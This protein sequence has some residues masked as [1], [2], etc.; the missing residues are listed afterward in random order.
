MVA[1]S[2]PPC[3]IL[4]YRSLDLDTITRFKVEIILVGFVVALAVPD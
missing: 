1:G 2:S 4:G 3:A